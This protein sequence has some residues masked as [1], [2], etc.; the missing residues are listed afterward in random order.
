MAVDSTEVELKLWLAPEDIITLRNHPRFP[1]SHDHTQEVLDSIYFDS[2]DLL[3]RD[4]RYNLRVRRIGDKCVQT[5]RST[6]QGVGLFERSEW[7]QTIEGDL[8]DLSR[9]K[10]A[11]LGRILIEDVRALKPV[12]ETRFERTAYHLNGNGAD[13]VM[14]IDEG[15]ILADDASRPISEIELELKHGS[16]TDLFKIA[17]DIVDIV[18]AELGFKSKSERGYELAEKRAVAAETAH[19]PE[20]NAGMGAGRAFTL[21]CR[22]CL[23]HLAAN[24]PLVLG[25]DGTALHQMR[26]AL[27]RLRAALSLFSAVVTDERAE[28]IKTELRWLARE[29]GPARDLD[30]LLLEVIKP[31]RQQYANEP[32]LVS[33]SNT[34]TRKRLKSYHHAQE[35][36]QSVR[37]R[38]LV[39]DTVEWVEVGPWSTSEDALFCARRDMPIR[40]FASEQLSHRYK[41]IRRRGAR[42]GELDPKQ[43]H[44]L[45]IQVKKARYATEFFSSLYDRKKSVK[46]CKNA[47]SSLMQLQRHLGRLNDIV[48]HKA[49]F[50]DITNSRARG[51]T[52][53]QSRRRAFAAGL[54]IGDQQAQIH[55]LLDRSRKAHSRFKRAKAFWKISS[56]SN[57]VAAPAA[58]EQL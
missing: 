2:D 30:T 28:T 18:P 20:L 22:A 1:G 8:P 38:K 12:F 14:A 32:G 57:T 49:L 24:V 6:D 4:H 26:V 56:R 31:L 48:T 5:I 13:I 25:R 3:L 15:L 23:R 27:R 45:R 19:N 44:S 17:R 42:I 33:I 21:V 55:K 37:F 54:V 50:V 41:K 46:Q 47:K 11:S 51:L 10:D 35:A 9:V 53:E 40:I 43:L 16:P 58:E 36:I 39:L 52:E 34:F 7:E 29:L